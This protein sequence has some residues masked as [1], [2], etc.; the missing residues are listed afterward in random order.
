MR[1]AFIVAFSLMIVGCAP[2]YRVRETVDEF[3]G[4]ENVAVVA[5]GNRIS[6]G[7]IAGGTHIDDSGVYVNP[8]LEKT[9]D[10]EI[11][12]AAFMVYNSTSYDTNYGSP[13]SLGA[14]NSLAFIAD[15]EA[16]Q[17][18]MINSDVSTSE[19]TFYN[20]VSRSAG[21][22]IRESAIFKTTTEDLRKLARAQSLRC[23]IKGSKRQ[24]E[25][26]DGDISKSF[27]GNLDSF[28]TNHLPK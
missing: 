23:Q 18:E 28:V 20:S 19:R 22:D 9:P 17:T 24:V 26:K 25:Y 11:I 10:G 5:E 3:S 8:V 12:S 1:F 6:A 16:I 13:N 14:I 15:G 21:F 2:Q 7:S 4:S 27:K